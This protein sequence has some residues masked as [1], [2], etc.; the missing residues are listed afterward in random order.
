VAG[1]IVLDATVMIAHLD[2]TDAHHDRAS[3]LLVAAASEAF[4]ASPLS[5]AEVLVG[6]TRAGR[7]ADAVAALE[8]LG[9]R[10]VSLDD[11][12]PSR[13]ATLRSETGLRLPDC[14]VLLAGEQVG[15]AVATFDERLGSAA[16]RQGLSVRDR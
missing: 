2:A 16:S 9:V 6:P 8:E 7:L 5:L 3:A 14:C 13:L 1:L 10:A 4:M 12:A 11:D 15:A